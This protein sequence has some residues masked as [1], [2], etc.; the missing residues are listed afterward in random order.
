MWWMVYYIIFNL[1][2]LKHLLFKNSF[3]LSI[4]RIRHICKGLS[5]TRKTFLH[6]KQY[7]R[8]I[9]DPNFGDKMFLKI[10]KQYIILEANKL[11]QL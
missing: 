3:C 11:S 9:C 6:L 2:D 4:L 7:S 1:K 5:S 8:Q 10:S